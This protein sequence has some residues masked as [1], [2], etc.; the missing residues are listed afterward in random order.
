MFK[1]FSDVKVS[2]D[3]TQQIQQSLKSLGNMDVYVGI[4]EGD[5]GTHSDVSNAELMYILSHGV[6]GKAMR[7]EMDDMM[8]FGKDGPYSV[9]FNKFLE[10]MDGGMPYSAAYELY[11]HEHGSPL[12]NV[13]PRPI[14]EPA[15]R[16]HKEKIALEL[17]KAAET[18]L[19]GQDPT[20]QLH[21]AGMLG[22]NVARDWFYD[23]EN[24]WPENAESTIQAKGSER[25]NVD[26]GN[27]RNSI[28][29]VVVANNQEL[30][31][32][33]KGKLKVNKS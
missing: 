27:L 9:G 26:T 15:I 11:I 2:K 1:A 28:V 30:A 25:P 5:V 7:E 8:Q 32:G 12:W 4:P 18:A 19:S 33:K 17:R 10:N 14:L 29:Y 13:P 31:R 21:K 24:R 22:Q 23:P 16:K 3:L 6:R 20:A